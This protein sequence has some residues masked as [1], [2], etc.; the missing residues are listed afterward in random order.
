MSTVQALNRKPQAKTMRPP[1]DQTR[2]D[3]TVVAQ[4]LA[5]E[6]N[7]FEHLFAKY[8]GH[9]TAVV[10]RHVPGDRVAEN[11]QDAFVRAFQSLDGWK[12]NAPFRRWLSTIAVRTCYDFW[13]QQYR[14]REIP[15]SRLSEAH[16][17]WLQNSLS[18]QSRDDW[19]ALGRQ[20]EAREILDWALDRLG[21]EDRMV[22]ELVYLE[23]LA[24]KE[25]ARLLG[26][27]TANVKVR[28]H[29]ARKKIN[30]WLLET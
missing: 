6:V 23:G 12:A 24:V 17:E 15:M 8:R 16:Q 3:Q 29:R 10:R 19:E 30:R 13:R 14:S 27:S 26:W 7:A 25:A 2:E 9:V 1:V 20:N 28:A 5:G 4:V 21:P 11:V 18:D 22:L